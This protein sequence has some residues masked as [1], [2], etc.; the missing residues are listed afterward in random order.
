MGRWGVALGLACGIV[1]AVSAG[2]P[3]RPAAEY[4]RKPLSLEQRVSAAEAVERVRYLHRVGA[5]LPFERAVPRVGLEE[6]VRDQLRRSVALD[7]RWQAPVTAAMLR[8]EVERMVRE[9]QM[10]ERLREY[11]DIL[12]NDPVLIEEC[13]ARPIVVDRLVREAFDSDSSI[14]AKAWEGAEAVRA[15]LLAGATP[16]AAAGARVTRVSRKAFVLPPTFARPPSRVSTVTDTKDALVVERVTAVRGDIEDVER[17]EVPK[18][19]WDA[20]WAEN[21]GSFDPSAA[22]TVAE[23]SDVLPPRPAATSALCAPDATWDNG[24]LDAVPA[25]RASGTAVWT[26]DVVIFWGGFSEIG[27]FDSGSL[28]DP[29]IDSWRA[30]SR[31]GAPAARD[32]HTAVWTGTQMIV[33]GGEDYNHGLPVQ[34]GSGGRYDPLTDTWSPMTDAGAPAPRDAHIA[35]WTG[36]EMLVWGGHSTVAFTSHYCLGD[37]AAYNPATDTW[38]PIDPAGAPSVRQ[39]HAAAWTGHVMVVFGGWDEVKVLGNGKMYDPVQN[40]WTA[41]STDGEPSPRVNFSAVWTGRW[42]VVWG[43]YAAGGPLR[44]GARFDPVTNRWTPINVGGAPTARL[45]ADAIWSGHEMIVWGGQ[46]ADGSYLGDGGRYDPV[47]NRWRFLPALNAPS[48]RIGTL[49][50]WTG[51]EFVVWGGGSTTQPLGD[52]RRYD[53]VADRWRP[54]SGSDLPPGRQQHTTLWTGDRALVWGGLVPGPLQSAFPPPYGLV[55][56]PAMQSWS[57]MSSLNGPF[58]DLEHSS[59]V[60]TGSQMIVWGGRGSSI[61]TNHGWRYDPSSDVWTPTSLDGAPSPRAGHTAVWS[62]TEMIV[63]GGEKSSAGWAADGARYDPLADTWRSMP[64]LD[65]SLGRVYHVAYWTGGEMLVWGGW[66]TDYRYDNQ[67][68]LFDPVSESWRTMSLTGGAEARDGYSSGWTGTEFLVWGGHPSGGS[69]VLGTGEAY[70][71]TSDT[72]RPISDDGAPSGRA[73]A[74]AVWDG[75]HF[76]VWGGGNGGAYGYLDTGALYDPASDTW[77]PTPQ[78]HAPDRTMGHTATWTGSFV[79]VW[80]GSRDWFLTPIPNLGGR[81]VMGLDRDD[82]GDGYSECQGDCD[83]D[84][85]AIHPGATEVCDGLDD[86]CDGVADPGLGDPDGDGVGACADNCP[87]VANPDQLDFDGDGIGD[88][89]ETGVALM[90]VDNSGRVDG[91]DLSILGRAFGASSP[92]P[93]YDPRAD[94]DRNGIVDGDDLAAL[95]HYWGRSVAP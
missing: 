19:S 40:R 73:G 9:T 44:S 27:A 23:A 45:R 85:P 42:F 72:W 47:A 52:G 48:A 76:V 32:S 34:F 14:H 78:L 93:R 62:G 4:V 35:V 56:D 30:M 65:P 31:V 2:G 57:M 33:W 8:A 7:R 67:G 29:A 82:D 1:S 24:P 10:P 16:P 79:F 84:N 94:F 64:S 17:Y 90:D 21:R 77:Q 46:A 71:P 41:L 39:G 70:N 11:F 87:T 59:A 6:R 69:I 92:D 5:A 22:E 28:Y 58:T 13:L 49:H 3:P 68:A 15:A 43:G 61:I 20:W 53:P 55:Y 86:N 12:G 63:W 36:T 18:R 60:W 75:A 38:R 54:M 88:A 83:D 81:L 91:V 66:A 74:A 50:A 25:P 95:G 26:G 89:C 51:T 37:G 80:G